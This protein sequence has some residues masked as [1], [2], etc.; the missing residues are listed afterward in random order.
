MKFNPFSIFAQE[1][2]KPFLF[3]AEKY[4]QYKIGRGTY[5]NLLIQTAGTEATLEIG[6]FC[7]IAD[8]VT[9][10]LQ[11][12]HRPD[13]VTTYPFSA[14]WPSCKNFTGHPHTKGDV[15]IGHDVWIG[16]GAT[17]MSGVSIGTGAVV[18]SHAVVTKDVRP[19]SIVA[20]NPARTIK[21][22]FPESIVVRL[23]NSKWWEM[24]DEKLLQLM[25]LLLSNRLEEFL[26][27]VEMVNLK[28]L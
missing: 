14:L 8:N 6:C 12:E 24:T 15:K 9:I 10:F 23:L 3:L 11:A 4:P 5:G 26:K 19:Y 21:S 1:M 7:S 13:W 2:K 16:F 17:I 28:H 27:E 22:R 25:P 20:G 18:G